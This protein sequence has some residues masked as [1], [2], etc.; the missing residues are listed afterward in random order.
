MRPL[1]D[2]CPSLRISYLR[3]EKQ[4]ETFYG[5]EQAGLWRKNDDECS[6]ED[7]HYEV[8]IFWDQ[9]LE[10]RISRRGRGAS[11]SMGGR[12]KTNE[13]LTWWHVGTTG[14]GRGTRARYSKHQMRLRNCLPHLVCDVED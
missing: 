5:A 9:G 3:C 4:G 1:N 6:C 11:C 14:G 8:A 2:C 10:N 13:E 7:I 12:G